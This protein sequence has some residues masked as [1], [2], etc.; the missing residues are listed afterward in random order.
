MTQA[1]ALDASATEDGPSAPPHA[2]LRP[3]CAA[4]SQTHRGCDLQVRVL[5]LPI[6]TQFPCR[7]E[8]MLD[9]AAIR[10][11]ASSSPCNRNATSA[12]D[13]TTASHSGNSSF[14]AAIGAAKRSYARS[15]SG[16]R[17]S[18]V[19]TLPQSEQSI[20]T[21]SS[22]RSS[23]SYSSHF[24]AERFN[25]RCA[26]GRSRSSLAAQTDVVLRPPRDR[27]AIPDT[28]SATRFQT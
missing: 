23:N 12:G 9:C 19:E 18:R 25:A 24:A 14:T 2:A 26:H 3:R 20:S 13:S 7:C 22:W 21:T 15:K 11:R 17:T 1:T 6:R 4:V 5:P 27:F 8:T 28:H 16:Q 10:A